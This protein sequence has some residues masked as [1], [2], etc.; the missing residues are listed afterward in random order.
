MKTTIEFIDA[1]KSRSGV[2]SDYALAPVLGITRAQ[3]SKFRNRK[4]F[5]GDSTAMK[6]GKLLQ[7]DP[8][9]VV[10]CAHAERAREDAE[11]SLWQGL[12][13]KLAP[14][15]LCIMLNRLKG[16][17]SR[18]RPVSGIPKISALA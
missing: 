15:T 17:T 5:L 4:D 9:Y 18:F 1:V 10:A 8:A 16:K 3:V 2:A 12:A 13:A 11:K 14:E 6:V 7:I